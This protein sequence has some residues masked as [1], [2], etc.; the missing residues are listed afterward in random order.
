MTWE[1]LTLENHR[2]DARIMLQT[3]NNA[4]FIYSTFASGRV[5]NPGCRNTEDHLGKDNEYIFLQQRVHFS[6]RNINDISNPN[7]FYTGKHK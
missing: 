5:N 4:P 6:S 1:F 7:V 2:F 3:A